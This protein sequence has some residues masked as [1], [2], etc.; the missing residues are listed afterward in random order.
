[1]SLKVFARQLGVSDVTVWRWEKGQLPK[2]VILERIALLGKK[3][4]VWILTG[5]E[6]LPR[7]ELAEL[8][9][10]LPLRPLVGLQPAVAEAPEPYGGLNPSDRQILR[11]VQDGCQTPPA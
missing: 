4:L 8:R 5:K 7:K 2:L 3:S 11:E 1:M 9:E 10:E 6:K